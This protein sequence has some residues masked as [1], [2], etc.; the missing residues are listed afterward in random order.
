MRLGST[1]SEKTADSLVP[2][3]F[4]HPRVQGDLTKTGQ[5]ACVGG[6]GMCIPLIGRASPQ[7]RTSFSYTCSINVWKTVSF[8]SSN[9]REDG[10]CLFLQWIKHFHANIGGDERLYVVLDS[11]A[12]HVSDDVLLFAMDHSIIIIHLHPYTTYLGW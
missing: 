12:G 2:R 11:G 3:A 6:D 4:K 8:D 7:Q 10:Q 9:K 5:M 1:G